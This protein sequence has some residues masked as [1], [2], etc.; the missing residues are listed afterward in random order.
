MDPNC[1]FH[2]MD[3]RRAWEEHFQRH[4]LSL[5]FKD[6]DSIVNKAQAELV[7]AGKFT[8]KPLER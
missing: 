5:I 7:S 8:E 4:Y 1:G 6:T 3:A 2:S